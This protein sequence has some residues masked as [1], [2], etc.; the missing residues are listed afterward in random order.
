MTL[1]A[2]E[3]H[4]REELRHAAVMDGALRIAR[5]ADVSPRSIGRRLRTIGLI[6]AVSIVSCIGLVVLGILGLPQAPALR[7]A[8][9]FAVLLAVAV[10]A[11]S[12]VAAAIVLWSQNVYLHVLLL[13]AKEEAATATEEL[14]RF[15]QTV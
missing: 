4:S 7:A 10:A 5:M 9:A 2:T 8:A 12:I 3:V 13:D 14:R 15:H 6:A 11:L 1:R